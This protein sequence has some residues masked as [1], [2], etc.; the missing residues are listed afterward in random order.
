MLRDLTIKNYRCFQDFAIDG[1][2]RVNLIVGQNN[3]GKTSFL[4]AVYLLVNQLNYRALIELLDVRGE[5]TFDPSFYSG[6][7]STVIYDMAHLFHDHEP[8][9]QGAPQKIVICSRHDQ[10]QSIALEF[11]DN[12]KA[13]QPL[14]LMSRSEVP[15]LE[16]RLTYAGETSFPLDLLASYSYPANRRFSRA[17]EVVGPNRF[18]PIDVGDF[19]YLSTLWETLSVDPDKEEIL[20]EGLRIIDP[21][22]VDIRF[23]SRRTASGA[24]VGLRGRS[25]RVPMSSMGEGLRRT[26]ALTMSALSS[27]QGVLLVDEIDTGLHHEIQPAVWRLLI[28]TAQRLDVQIFATTHSWDCIVA[29]Q[30]AL[31]QTRNGQDNLGLLFRLQER[32]GNIVPL[33]YDADKLDV[34]VDHMIEVR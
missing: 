32:N 12:I 6:S 8:R 13:T 9:P 26:L 27:Q 1:L 7:T 18:V 34:A 10:P 4:E 23:N 30:E 17:R 29:F 2:A 20:V 22:V 28:E 11:A 3:S 25:Q 14:N 19:D 33:D 31:T 15:S 5:Y 16:L 24:V 21:N